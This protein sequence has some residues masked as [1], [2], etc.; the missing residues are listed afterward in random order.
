M[1]C[2]A[3]IEAMPGALH[4]RCTRAAHARHIPAAD[5]VI[6]PKAATCWSLTLCH[7]RAQHQGPY[8]MHLAR[9]LLVASLSPPPGCAS[10]TRWRAGSL[11]PSMAPRSRRRGGLQSGGAAR[12]HAAEQQRTGLRAGHAQQRSPHNHL[13]VC[14][15]ILETF[16]KARHKNFAQTQLTQGSVRCVSGT[17]AVE[18]RQGG[19]RVRGANGDHA[20]SR[21][22]KNDDGT[23]GICSAR[24]VSGGR[25]QAHLSDRL[26][27]RS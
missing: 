12:A 8:E 24:G 26:I 4:A 17:P 7:S 6:V 23:D 11:C 5:T 10:S 21:L 9:H 25:S 3:R 13:H 22:L 18:A 15:A 20:V 14:P 27:S 16:Y 2:E 19:G 1:R